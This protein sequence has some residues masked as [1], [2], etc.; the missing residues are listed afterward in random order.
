M[1]SRYETLLY[2]LN[3]VSFNDYK[4]KK[5][6]FKKSEIIIDFNDINIHIA[7]Q[8]AVKK[9]IIDKTLKVQKTSTLLE[10]FKESAKLLGEQY[11]LVYKDV[12]IHPPVCR[13]K[14]FGIVS[15]RTLFL[16]F[17]RTSSNYREL[18]TSPRLSFR[19]FL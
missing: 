18:Q 2:I 9:I 11:L 14:E 15:F 16:I 10:G 19:P 3:N 7:R 6:D 5:I 17:C 4:I 12:F 13:Q 8:M 1:S